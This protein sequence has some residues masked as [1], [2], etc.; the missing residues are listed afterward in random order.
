LLHEPNH[1]V[2]SCNSGPLRGLK[3]D[4]VVKTCTGGKKE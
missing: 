4:L 3:R 1:E 2:E